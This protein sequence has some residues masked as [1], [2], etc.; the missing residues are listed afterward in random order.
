MEVLWAVPAPGYLLD[1]ARGPFES[2]GM[3]GGSDRWKS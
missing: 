3:P 2:I 1:A